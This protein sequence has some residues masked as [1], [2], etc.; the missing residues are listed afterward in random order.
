[1]AKTRKNTFMT[2]RQQQRRR[3]HPES[4]AWP[5]VRL[6]VSAP[7]HRE[8][9]RAA[10]PSARADKTRRRQAQERRNHS[11]RL[12]GSG[13]GC[14]RK[15]RLANFGAAPA[16]AIVNLAK[17]QP[18]A[19]ADAHDHQ[20]H[21][22][23]QRHTAGSCGPEAQLDTHASTVQSAACQPIGAQQ[24]DGHPR[25][26]G[27]S[28]STVALKKMPR[29]VIS[30][31]NWKST[32]NQQ[33]AGPWPIAIRAS[34]FQLTCQVREAQRSASRQMLLA[35]AFRPPAPAGDAGTRSRFSAFTVGSS[36][37]DT[38]APRP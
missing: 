26:C 31:M 33:T 7:V 38:V 29:R 24:R 30:G 11:Q 36:A 6:S 32:A 17:L 13:C 34:Y 3:T 22:E 5:S 9:A 14:R 1:M 10:G 28:G 35:P 27:N 12:R 21:G 8:A 4:C 18:V 15:L 19:E 2:A 20:Q 37:P 16:I 25:S 23:C